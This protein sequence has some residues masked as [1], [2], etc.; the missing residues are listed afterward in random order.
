MTSAHIDIRQAGSSIECNRQD[1]RLI[2]SLKLRC[3]PLLKLLIAAVCLG[4]GLRLLCDSA[5][6]LI[7]LAGLALLSRVPRFC[8]FGWCDYRALR[9]HRIAFALSRY[10]RTEPVPLD[11][12]A[13][14]PLACRAF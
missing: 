11:R 6:P 7:M 1:L 14:P 2:R 9:E 13:R 5:P 3:R 12:P 4:L 10:L 8:Y